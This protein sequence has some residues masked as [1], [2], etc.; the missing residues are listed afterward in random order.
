MN[1]ITINPVFKAH[2]IIVRATDDMMRSVSPEPA[3]NEE[4]YEYMTEMCS[5]VLTEDFLDGTYTPM[6]YNAIRNEL[7]KVLWNIF[8]PHIQK[9][10]ET[11]E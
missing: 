5:A 9:E 1:K 11:N 10:H 2:N 6:E 4:L 8:E 3:N 7:A